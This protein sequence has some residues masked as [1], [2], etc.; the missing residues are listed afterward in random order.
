M[1]NLFRWMCAAGVAAGVITLSSCGEQ[2]PP[3]PDVTFDGA[4]ALEYAKLQ[5]DAGPRVPGTEPH[6]LVADRIVAEMRKNADTVIEQAWT[7]KAASGADLPMRNIFA[8]FNPSA[9]KRILYISHYDTRPR[10]DNEFS[11]DAKKMPIPGAND[12]AS[13]T[14]LLLV[15]AEALKAA[16]PPVG[17]DLLFTDGE[18][19]GDFGPPEVDV[20]IGAKYFAEH[21]LPVASY[22]P[23]FGILWD[24]VG[25]KTLRIARET[26]SDS[27][28]KDLN[29]R[30]WKMA[31]RLGYANIFI[32]GRQE[33]RDDH[34]AL[35]AKGWNVVD[36][37]DDLR[38]Y[39]AHHKLSDTIDKL[40]A[41][42][43]TAV[44][45]VALAL[46]RE[47]E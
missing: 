3:P 38:G 33:V 9:T 25:S 21:P 22:K 19:Y 47:K 42:S 30:I 46:I 36:I 6:R 4:R 45:R 32:E 34:L 15:L 7:H 13:N 29:D 27:H 18:D 1:K 28:S 16:P 11:E 41:A 40:S 10:A 2:L 5:V 37:I 14:A 44:G 24:M 8:Q 35:I 39:D 12:G 26:Y 31:A 20:F 17:V 43:L 23:D